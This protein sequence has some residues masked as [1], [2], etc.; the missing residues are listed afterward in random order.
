MADTAHDVLRAIDAIYWRWLNGEISQEDAL[1]EIG[2]L[3]DRSLGDAPKDAGPS[4]S[5]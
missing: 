2:D 3:L 4:E 1:F 5:H